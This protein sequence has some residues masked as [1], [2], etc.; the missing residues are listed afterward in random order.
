MRSLE[1]EIA[2]YAIE[3]ARGPERIQAKAVRA[4]LLAMLKFPREESDERDKDRLLNDPLNLWGVA[5]GWRC[6][7]GRHSECQPLG[8]D[9]S[10]TCACGVGDH[11]PDQNGVPTEGCDCGHEGMGVFWHHP[12]CVWKAAWPETIRQAGRAKVDFAATEPSTEEVQRLWEK[13]RR[14]V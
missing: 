8:A 1:E 14:S 7:V 11:A 10:C 9:E 2:Q 5:P 12:D 3:L 6:W 4:R 13:R